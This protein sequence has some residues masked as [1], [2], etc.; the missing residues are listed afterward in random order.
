[1]AGG[2]HS[3]GAYGQILLE[4]GSSPHTFDA[5]SKA[6]RFLSETMTEHGRILSTQ[7][8]GGGTLQVEAARIRSGIGF[9]YGEIVLALSPNDVDVLAEHVWSFTESPTDTWAQ[10][11]ALNYF[12]LLIDTDYYTWEFTDCM[13]TDWEISARAPQ[14]NEQGQPELVLCKLG[15]RASGVTAGT[16]WPGSPP[17]L[18]VAAVDR[19]YV[20][21]DSDGLFSFE[22]TAR[23]IQAFRF[24]VDRGLYTKYANA[25]PA[26]SQRST[27]RHNQ[28]VLQLPWNSDNLDLYNVAIAG[29]AGSF[30]FANGAFSSL[31]NLGRVHFPNN[32]PI[33]RGKG[34]VPLNLFGLVTGTGATADVQ[35]VNDITP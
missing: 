11:D 7:G 8:I 30:K 19:P 10:S 31:F 16:S 21:S 32:T 22:S 18:G 15:I 26:H 29:S 14:F 12:G 23:P 35:I 17:S 4:P 34:E 20:L 9:T 24:K 1:M 5:S 28:I 6:I 13:I 25:T 27:M 33:I 2:T 3:Q